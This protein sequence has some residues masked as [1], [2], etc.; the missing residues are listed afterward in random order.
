MKNQAILK[1]I[2]ILLVLSLC[3][4]IFFEIADNFNKAEIRNFDLPIISFVQG[5][6][7]D[8]MTSVM[9]AITF[10]GSVQGAA[11]I[12]L[13]F[14]L[15]LW[16]K[17]YRTLSI[18]LAVSVALGA[19]VFNRILKYIFKRQRPDIMRVIQETGYSFPSGHSMGSM[20]LFG[21][22]VFILF[23]V[24]KKQWSKFA[25]T[26]FAMFIVLNIGISRIYLGV[27]YPS[28]VVGGYAAGLI[29]VILSAMALMLF[30]RKFK[31]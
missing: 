31:L 9:L 7:S 23:R 21:C 20:I 16:I 25:G 19:G 14:V 27:H 28:D 10:L 22:L 5:F 13:I 11:S 24:V 29:W 26:L 2:L 12:T 6:I 15:I 4:W 8:H 1:I 18:Y 3:T 17:K 30:E